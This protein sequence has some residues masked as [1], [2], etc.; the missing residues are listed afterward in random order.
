VVVFVIFFAVV[1]LF[2]IFLVWF[3]E[4]FDAVG[5]RKPGN[6]SDPIFEVG[7]TSVLSL[8]IWRNQ[9][10]YTHQLEALQREELP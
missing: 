10:V 7:S 8:D 9:G 3:K 4:D 2:L 1:F 6:P 5:C